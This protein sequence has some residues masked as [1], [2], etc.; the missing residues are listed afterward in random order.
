MIILFIVLLNGVIIKIVN[1]TAVILLRLD[2]PDRAQDP[3][4]QGEEDG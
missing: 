3:F 2:L 4:A 1:N